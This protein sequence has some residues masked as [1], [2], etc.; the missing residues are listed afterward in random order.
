MELL[1][2]KNFVIF[3]TWFRSVSGGG[4]EGDAADDD[5]ELFFLH[6]AVQWSKKTKLRSF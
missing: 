1:R 4:G 3:I 5:D 2:C 6:I